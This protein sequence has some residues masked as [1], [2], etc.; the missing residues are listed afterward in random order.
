ME[1]NDY[2]GYITIGTKLDTSGI[3]SELSSMRKSLSNELSGIEKSLNSNMSKLETGI[4]KTLSILKASIVGVGLAML[5]KQISGSIDGAISRLD[6]MSN[7]TKVMA[8]LGIGADDAK[9]SIDILSEKLKGLPTT[10]DDAVRSVQR[11]T[12]ANNNVKASTQMFLALNNAILAGGANAQ[13]QATALEQLSQAYTKGKPDMMEW[14]TAMMAMPAQL[15][16]VA[17]TMG[18]VNADELGE[19]LRK[20]TVSMN[21]FMKTIMELNT[22]GG[23]G[24][25]SFEEQAKTA[26]GGIATAMTNVKTA[27]TRGLAQIME[28]IGQ[29]NI[30]GFFNGISSA[31]SKVIPYVVSFVKVIMTAVS[32]INSLFGGSKKT[33]QDTANAV[34]DASSSMSSLGSS[35]DEASSGLDK[36]TGSAKALNKE[37]KTTAS[38]DELNIIKDTSSS[39]G[40][41]SSGTSGAG[42]IDLSGMDFSNFDLTSGLEQQVDKINELISKIN[43]EP[44]KK[45]VEN[46]AGA[47]K[48]LG[49]GV[50]SIL[51]E[52]LEKYIKP[53][54]NYVISDALPRF[55]N[56]TAEAI[57]SIDFRKLLDGFSPLFS[58]LETFTENVGDGFL[59]IYENVLLPLGTWT[60]NEVLPELL[61]ILAKAIKIVNKA[62]EDLKPLWK[63]FWDKV[64]KPI[65]EYTGGIFVDILKGIGDA[66]KW[67]SDNEYAMAILEG[68]IVAI[69][70]VKVA[71]G[72][73]AIAMTV[74]TVATTA[75]GAIMAVLTSPITLV[76]LA[77]TALIAII[78]LCVKHWDEIKAKA[79]EVW[80]KIKDAWQKANEWF[81]TKVV[82]PIVDKF[83]NMWNGLKTGAQ[84]AWNGI[85]S[86]FSK[87][88]SFFKETFSKAWEKVKDVF[89]R[90]GQVFDGIK[91]GIVETFKN[92]V[93]GLITGINKVV[94]VPFEK[95]N[96]ILAKLR[97]IEIFG[98][99][100]FSSIGRISVPKIPYLKTGAII[101]MPNRRN[102]SRWNGICWR[103]WK[104]G[105]FTINR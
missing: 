31:I 54:A 83:T 79:L 30:A 102:I 73:Y 90:G 16:Q 51:K 36:A 46:L 19:A 38:F 24:F 97:D 50:A 67:I 63:F 2:D 77:I 40:G 57:K 55:L 45:S 99:Q 86:V 1:S 35:S 28:A 48:Y 8:N 70:A 84:N 41:S 100:P 18:Y 7:Y 14:R 32:Y 103:I 72:L 88:A 65:A 81:N 64:L 52:F 12:S 13:I 80:Q 49:G 22:K 10:L 98:A 68:L 4:T 74:A 34:N 3:T 9:Q 29:S 21:D 59:W 75:F 71:L 61:N 6:T 101:N 23:N 60:I 42:G 5:F 91:E 87:V 39:G 11:F 104:R 85:K 66:L 25:T 47:I 43:L 89:S 62:I 69:I 53:L 20:G 82:Q 94:S 15:K 37:L 58:A 17:I 76:V 26:T 78:I 33:I 44:L 27:I 105:C 56:A 96:S 95:L 92:I 93:N